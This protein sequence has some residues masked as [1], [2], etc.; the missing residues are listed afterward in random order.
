MPPAW[1]EAQ[2]M[3]HDLVLNPSSVTVAVGGETIWQTAALL[4]LTCR[5]HD[6]SNTALLSVYIDDF[7]G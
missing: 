6:D 4:H 2:E 5:T 7:L 1:V 3:G